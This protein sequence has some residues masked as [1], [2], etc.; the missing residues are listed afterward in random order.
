MA[1]QEGQQLIFPRG[2]FQR[3]AVPEDLMAVR[4]DGEV[5]CHRHGCG[6]SGGGVHSRAADVGSH[7]GDQLPHGEGL[8]NVIIGAD[9]K[10]GHLVGLLLPCGED[11]DGHVVALLPEGAAHVEA[12]HLRQHHVQQD[13]VGVF[14]PG[15]F[16]AVGSVIGLHGAVALSLKVKAQNVYDIF[17]VLH[18]EDGFLGVRFLFQGNVPPITGLA[19][20]W[21]A[22]L[23][24]RS[25]RHR[26]HR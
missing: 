18:N 6:R 13:Q 20:P 5:P 19:G 11:D 9:L 8:G 23:R 2:Q 17:F 25:W 7:P 16:Q 21:P 12:D 26:S 15:L 4:V 3:L 22:G 10:T 1:G 24:P 14:L